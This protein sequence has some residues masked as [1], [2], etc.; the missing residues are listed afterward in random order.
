MFDLETYKCLESFKIFRILRRHW[1]EA[2]LDLHDWR[3][4][5]KLLSHLNF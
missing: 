1:L 4:N 5:T 3:N 2:L